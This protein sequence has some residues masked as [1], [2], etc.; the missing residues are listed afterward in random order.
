MSKGGENKG[1]EK[2]GGKVLNHPTIKSYYL[3]AIFFFW[4]EMSVHIAVCNG[5]HCS[6]PVVSEV[7]H[8]L[9]L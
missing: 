6:S 2:R 9:S 3:R 1:H 4:L 7:L 5:T 8:G